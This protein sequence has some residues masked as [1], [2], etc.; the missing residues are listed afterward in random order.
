MKF[1]C[2]QQ[3]LKQALLNVAHIAG[4]NINLPILNNILINAQEGGIEFVTTD[5][6]IGA[7]CSIR[8]KVDGAGSFT[9]NAKLLSDYINLLPNARVDCEL[10]EGEFYIVCENF[11][12]NIKGEDAVDFP[13][14][15]KVERSN[16]F[17]FNG[18]ELK[19]ALLEVIFAAAANETRIELS[20]VYFELNNELVL[21]ATDSY[22]L[23][24]RTIRCHEHN[25]SPDGLKK[26]I[27]PTKTL[28]EVVRIVSNVKGEEVVPEKL[29]HDVRIFFSD[30]QVLFTYN[31]FELVSRVIEGQYPDYRQIIPNIGQEQKTVATIDRLELTRAIKA[32]SLFS[33][34]DVNDVNLDFSRAGH[35]IVVSALNGSSGSS[36]IEVDADVSGK[37]NSIVLNY[38][39]LLDGLNNT[40]SERVVLEVV[41]ANTPCMLKLEE[42]SD[43]IYL[44]MPIRK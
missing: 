10:R 2:T 26:I 5:L 32:S 8:G 12:T 36:T 39:Y 21:A 19:Q 9:V 37:D 35:H 3:N 34:T 22:R 23:A 11:K 7:T 16:V 41:D 44:I 6:E 33:K 27:I 31:N 13:L 38:R 28:Q 17:S 25:S 29:N 30:N 42:R 18:Q 40:A 20:G 1:S 14:I 4:K 43:Y 15:P 24:E